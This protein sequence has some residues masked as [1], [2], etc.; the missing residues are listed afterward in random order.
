ME[1]T[2]R[3]VKYPN[4]KVRLTGQSGNAFAIIGAV[5]QA[6]KRAKV[7]GA[8]IHEFV[9]EA[10]SGDYNNVLQTAMRWVDVS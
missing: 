1:I 4:I 3:D 6:L 2:M 8:E 5:K 7:P 9:N 10:T